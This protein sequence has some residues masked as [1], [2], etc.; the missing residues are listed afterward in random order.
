MIFGRGISSIYMQYRWNNLVIQEN[1]QEWWRHLVREY[2]TLA[3]LAK[4]NSIVYW[5]CISILHAI[6]LLSSIWAMILMVEIGN[7]SKE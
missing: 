5:I 1:V 4:P 2:E 6:L 3:G 7:N